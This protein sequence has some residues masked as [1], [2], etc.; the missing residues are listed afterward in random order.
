MIEW[1]QWQ[2]TTSQHFTLRGYYTAAR[3]KPVVHFIHGNS[4]S[5]LTYLP[6]WEALY[7]YFDIFLHDA[8]GHG[9]SDEGGAFV[10]WNESAELAL[11]VAEEWL[12]QL[13]GKVPIYGCG[14]SF[15]GILTLLMTKQRPHLFNEL[16]LLDPILFLPSMIMP[17]RILSWFGVYS[18]NPYAKRARRRRS[19]WPNRDAALAG[20]QE[21]GMFR[22]WEP[23]ALGAYVDHAMSVQHD[24]QQQRSWGLKCSP[25]REAEIFSSYARGLWPAITQH[26]QTPTHVWGGQ[27][28]YPFL[29]KSLRKWRQSNSKV[30]L[31]WVP[32]GHCFMLQH[33]KQVADQI[34]QR[35]LGPCG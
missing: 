13:Y 12:P 11:T 22:G 33:P 9:D 34:R 21:R 4:Y 24:G 16:V 27:E 6:L 10:G 3:G 35:L 20:L 23:S 7:P 5:G 29:H 18:L 8:Q 28:T 26:L 25:Q 17:M 32:G 31:D 15:G 19:V 14:H 2:H 30:Q 1:L